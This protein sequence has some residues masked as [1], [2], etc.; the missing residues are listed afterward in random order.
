MLGN[1]IAD[2]QHVETGGSSQGLGL[3]DVETELQSHKATVQVRAQS[4]GEFLGHGCHVEGYEIHMGT[5]TRAQ[6]ISPCFRILTNQGP[7]SSVLGEERDDGA[8]SA[9]GLVWGTYIHGVF[10]RPEFRRQWLNRIRVRK[11][12]HPVEVET[13]EAVSERLDH[14]L[15]RWAD[16]VG[17]YLNMKPIWACI[18]RFP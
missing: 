6:T 1:I 3:L 11:K 4:L 16:H 17:T 10:D 2:P 9:D 14:A 5:T 18:G 12:L 15:D 7:S 8:M 13:S